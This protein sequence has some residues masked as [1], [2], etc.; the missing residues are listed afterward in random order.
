MF[1]TGKQEGEGGGTV[2]ILQTEEG[3]KTAAILY[4]KRKISDKFGLLN[5]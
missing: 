1:V 5:C 2:L 4:K 3:S